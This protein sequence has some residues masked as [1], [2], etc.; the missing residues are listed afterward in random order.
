MI[1]A[2]DQATPEQLVR[3]SAEGEILA[4]LQHPNIVQ[5]Y[6]VGAHNQRPYCALELM[7]GGSLDAVQG[8]KPLPAR[9]AAELIE[10]LG[11]AVEYAHRQGVVHRDLKPSNILLASGVWESPDGRSRDSRHPLADCLPKI[12][13]FGLAKHLDTDSRLT[14]TGHVMG[15]PNYMAPEQVRGQ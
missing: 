9:V 6:E 10:A 5:I 14:K 13:D 8:G 2:G 11:R 12:S 15:T 4:R 3:F 1:L 7:E